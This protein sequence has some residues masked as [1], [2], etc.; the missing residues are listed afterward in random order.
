[1]RV[2]VADDAVLIREG[3]VRLLEEF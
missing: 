2:V 1:M 3:L